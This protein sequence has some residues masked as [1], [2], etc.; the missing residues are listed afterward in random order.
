MKPEWAIKEGIDG[1]SRLFHNNDFFKDD[2]LLEGHY[3]HHIALHYTE[4]FS[5]CMICDKKIPE[6]ILTQWKLLNS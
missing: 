5:T 1:G 6:E 3:R 2:P 4:V